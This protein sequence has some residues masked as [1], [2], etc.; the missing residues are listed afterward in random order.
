MINLI[1]IEESG[2]ILNSDLNIDEEY[3]RKVNNRVNMFKLIKLGNN[4]IKLI[5][6]NLSEL[7]I[8]SILMFLNSD[9][10]ILI[11]CGERCNNKSKCFV[12]YISDL[13]KTRLTEIINKNNKMSIRKLADID[14]GYKLKIIE[15]PKIK[16]DSKENLVLLDFYCYFDYN[17]NEFNFTLQDIFN[18]VK[19]KGL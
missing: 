7:N 6:N 2:F 12:Y 14:D 13:S 9:E 16:L 1:K 8:Y 5:S 18:W 17:T 3:I 11:D 10:K 19:I 4:K 15:N